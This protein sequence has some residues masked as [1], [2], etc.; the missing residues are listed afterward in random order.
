[1][2]IEKNSESS[3]PC[4]EINYSILTVL[5]TH[6]SQPKFSL[7][8]YVRFVVVIVDPLVC[9][10]HSYRKSV[11]LIGHGHSMV[12]V[13]VKSKEDLEVLESL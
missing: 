2:V 11:R 3:Q 5:L 6:L 12:C 9:E 10:P 1:M 8:S 4:F 13:G 7:V